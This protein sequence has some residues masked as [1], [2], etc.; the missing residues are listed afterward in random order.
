M[1]KKSEQ[2]RRERRK[3]IQ[4]KQQRIRG[5]I[6]AHS[7]TLAEELN[8]RMFLD[9]ECTTWGE[10]DILCRLLSLAGMEELWQE[11]CAPERILFVE[12]IVVTDISFM[13]KGTIKSQKR[14]KAWFHGILTYIR[15]LLL[16][17]GRGRER[18]A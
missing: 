2:F 6:L 13:E 3:A 1:S 9:R 5:E 4:R 12:S 10:D 15:D 7:K 18:G 8:L 16:W 11:L 14:A 17:P